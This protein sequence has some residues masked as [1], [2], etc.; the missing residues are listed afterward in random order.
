MSVSYSGVKVF[1][2]T[3]AREREMLGERITGW[4]ADAGD[5]IELVDTKVTQSS[6]REFH[7]LT[8]TIFY[9]HR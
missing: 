5:S 4:L 9:E 8:I 7:C 2:A 1:S 3:K 6:D